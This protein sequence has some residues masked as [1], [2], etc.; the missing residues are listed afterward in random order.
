M[1]ALHE[2]NLRTYVHYNGVPGVWFFSLDANHA[3]AVWTARN[4]FH[5]PYFKA[6]MTLQQQGETITYSSTRTHKAA[7]PAEFHA[8]W[9]I[10]EA[11][12]PSTPESL[13][14]FL[15]ERYCLY[16]AHK[17][18]LHRLRI[19]HPIWPLRRARLSSFHSTM[20]ESLGVP[21][22]VGEPLLHYAEE[23]KVD[24]WPLVKM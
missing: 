3:P 14:F 7:P 22:P 6:R 15:T 17:E 19:F 23:L 10:G 12:E 1:S 4:F 5:L 21:T 9:N 16:A 20:V 8:T 13:A 11:L 24:I 18:K 2:L